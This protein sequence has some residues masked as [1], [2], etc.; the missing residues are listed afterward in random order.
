MAI[1]LTYA[2]GPVLDLPRDLEWTDEFDWSPVAQTVSISITGALIVESAAQL[3]GR[4]VTLAGAD[5]RAW[6]TRAV[7]DQLRAWA[8]V[9]DRQMTLTLDDGRVFAVRFD[10]RQAPIGARAI[11]P[12]WTPA[13]ADDWFVCTLKFM[14]V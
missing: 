11:V 3:S 10:Q 5:D 4:P 8:A 14:E 1:T 13:A 12:G 6:I 2:G 9:P 7:L